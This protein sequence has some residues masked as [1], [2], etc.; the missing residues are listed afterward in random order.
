MNEGIVKVYA[1]NQHC[2]A[3]VKLNDPIEGMIT[4]LREGKMKK[5]L[6]AFTANDGSILYAQSIIL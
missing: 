1:G 4:E 6:V 2:C 3:I 5:G